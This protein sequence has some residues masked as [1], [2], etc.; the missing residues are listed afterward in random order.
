M[1]KKHKKSRLLKLALIISIVAFSLICFYLFEIYRG[2][3]E[4]LETACALDY[5]S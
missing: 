3:K 2:G 4:K 1:E 5:S